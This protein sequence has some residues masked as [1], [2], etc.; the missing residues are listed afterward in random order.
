MTSN[1]SH[2]GPV[3]AE[4]ESLF[5]KWPTSFIMTG[6][7]PQFQCRLFAKYHKACISITDSRWFE[8][9]GGTK[10]FSSFFHSS[11]R[12]DLAKNSKERFEVLNLP[13]KST[14]ELSFRFASRFSNSFRWEECKNE[15]TKNILDLPS[16]LLSKFIGWENLNCQ[17]DSI[18]LYK[19]EGS[20]S[21]RL[22]MRFCVLKPNPV[23]FWMY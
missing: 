20:F 18:T 22:M 17:Q 1:Y 12:N 13:L 19:F 9:D 23:I 16:Y 3:T 5:V 11:H 8:N 4:E 14:K 6:C 21:T 2:M 15:K 7:F 10:L